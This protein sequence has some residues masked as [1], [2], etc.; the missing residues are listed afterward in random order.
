MFVIMKG[1]EALIIDSNEEEELSSLFETKHIKKIYILLTHEHYDHTSGVYWLQE[2]FET[3]LISNRP[4]AERIAEERR[5]IPKLVS[6]V[7]ANK[8]KEDGGNRYKEFKKKYRPYTLHAD[9]VYDTPCEFELMGMKFQATLTPGHSPGSWCLVV[10][11]TFVITGDTLIQNTP[12]LER[13]KESRPDE[14]RR[15]TLPYLKGLNENLYVLPG[16]GDPFV[17]KDNGILNK[18]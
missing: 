11:D 10:D 12:I 7:L 16:H 15:M 18:Y 6:F 1:E 5:N 2:N 4:C 14:F 13:F 17:L 3:T 8:D 9:V